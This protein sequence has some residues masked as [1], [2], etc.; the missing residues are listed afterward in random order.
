MA[1]PGRCRCSLLGFAVPVNRFTFYTGL[2]PHEGHGKGSVRALFFLLLGSLLGSGS[3]PPRVLDHILT[4]GEL[5][6]LS[7]NG[8]STF[9]YGSKETRGIDVE[10]ARRFATRLGVDLRIVV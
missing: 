3:S 5:R 2:P 10:L 7:H 1:S 6:F 9:Y 4:L 8:P